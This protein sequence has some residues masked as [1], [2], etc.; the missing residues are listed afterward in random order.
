MT[1]RQLPTALANRSPD[2]HR[3]AVGTVGLKALGCQPI[4][5]PPGPLGKLPTV[6]AK[7]PERGR[8]QSLAR[9]ARLPISQLS[10][11]VYR[12]KSLG[13]PR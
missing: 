11:P 12:I 7:R 6:A 10:A 9:T 13:G 2:R 5:Q 4:G 1:A 3:L 8:S